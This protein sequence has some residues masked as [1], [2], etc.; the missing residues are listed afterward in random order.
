MYAGGYLFFVRGGHIGGGSLTAQAF[1]PDRRRLIGNPVPLGLPAAVY[2][3]YPLGAFSVSAELD[4]L[5]YL[6][7]TAEIFDLVWHNRSGEKVGT[8]GDPGVYYHLDISPD[9]GRV[10]GPNKRWKP[11][12]MDI[13]TIDP[14]GWGASRP[15]TRFEVDPARSATTTWRSTRP[16]PRA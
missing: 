3:P 7:R 8:V 15:M 11:L 16:G 5:V 4:R 10:G 13:W 14:A 2:S 9:D 12:Q 6:P 1:D